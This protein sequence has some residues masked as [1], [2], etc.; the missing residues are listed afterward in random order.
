M[1]DDEDFFTRLGGR[2]NNTFQNRLRNAPRDD[3]DIPMVAPSLFEE[4]EEETP[5]QRLVRHWMNERHAPDV[6]PIPEDRLSGPLDHTRR[7]VGE[8]SASSSSSSNVVCDMGPLRSETAQLLRPEPSS[9]EEEHFRIMFAQTEVERVKFVIRS[10]LRTRLFKV[11]MYCCHV[12]LFVQQTTTTTDRKV[13]S[14]YHDQP[15][16]QRRLSENE[17]DHT[18]RWRSSFSLYEAS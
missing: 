8:M 11:S 5:L 10:Y 18:R 6:L 14:I 1:D 9:S 16:V 17:V 4:D 12:T 13:C 2:N 7:Q 3:D 15:E